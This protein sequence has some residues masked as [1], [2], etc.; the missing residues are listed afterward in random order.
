MHVGHVEKVAK[1]FLE[2][3]DESRMGSNPIALKELFEIYFVS[4]LI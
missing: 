2:I 1:L 4:K 3:S